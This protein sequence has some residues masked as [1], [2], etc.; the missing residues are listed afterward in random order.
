[1]SFTDRTNVKRRVNE[2]DR[3]Q[4]FDPRLSPDFSPRLRDNGS[5]HADTIAQKVFEKLVAILRGQLPQV[6]ME[7]D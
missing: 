3:L 5:G 4:R 7:A 2:Q 1:M 6:P